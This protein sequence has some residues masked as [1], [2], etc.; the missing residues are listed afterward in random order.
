MGYQLVTFAAYKLFQWKW[1]YSALFKE[2]TFHLSILYLV[3]RGFILNVQ[4]RTQYI[5]QSQRHSVG[6]GIR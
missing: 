3:K 6:L 2:V 4:L 1:H 5:T